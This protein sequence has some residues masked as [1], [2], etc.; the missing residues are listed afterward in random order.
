M[1]KEAHTAF[2]ELSEIETRLRQLQS[3]YESRPGEQDA[4]IR[5]TELHVEWQAAVKR[6]TV[7]NCNFIESARGFRAMSYLH[8]NQPAGS[9]GLD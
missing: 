3:E 6:F 5:I 7:L 4:H 9:A 8:R 2:E 1:Y